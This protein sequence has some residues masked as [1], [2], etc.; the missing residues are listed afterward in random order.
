MALVHTL[1]ILTTPTNVCN[2]WYITHWAY[3]S[4]LWNLV[5]YKTTISKPRSTT[6]LHISLFYMCC[7]LYYLLYTFNQLCTWDLRLTIPLWKNHKIIGP[8]FPHGYIFPKY[9]WRKLDH[10]ILYFSA[11]VFAMRR[12]LLPIQSITRHQW[13][14]NNLI[15]N[16]D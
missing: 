12:K 5:N 1:G 10:D 16:V 14:T 4:C 15:C 11:V 9:I 3:C 13:T 7:C 6:E 8:S 2:T